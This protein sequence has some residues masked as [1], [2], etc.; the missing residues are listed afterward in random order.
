M[1]TPCLKTLFP[2]VVAAWGIFATPAVIRADTNAVT[3]LVS[4]GVGYVNGAAG[5]SFTPA[6]NLM[7]TRVGYLEYPNASNPIVSLWSGTNYR[8]ANFPLKPGTNW[9]Q[10]NYTNVS[11]VLLAGQRYAL[12]AQDG[13]FF[14]AHPFLVQ[15]CYSKTQFQ[16]ATQLLGYLGATVTTNGVWGNALSEVLLLG[17]NFSFQNQSGPVSPP[18]LEITRS[19]ASTAILSWPASPAGYVLQ[20]NGVMPATNWVLATNLVSVASGTN[21]V[22]V[23]PLKDD[24]FFRLIH[25]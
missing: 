4:D 11:L 3:M 10:M 9:G 15:A 20:Q 8:I 12:T 16:V 21:R 7:V 17:P 5:F 14:A 24:L 13:P 23:S 6:T 1:K 2:L 25:P 19:N 22:V 18:V